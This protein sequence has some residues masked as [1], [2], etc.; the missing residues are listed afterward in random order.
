MIKLYD[1]VIL[2]D[3]REGCVVEVWD[4]EHFSVDVGSSPKDWKNIE[5][6]KD[7]LDLEKMKKAG[8]VSII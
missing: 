3:G 1:E 5:V 4:D 2:K 8:L 6:S 7:D